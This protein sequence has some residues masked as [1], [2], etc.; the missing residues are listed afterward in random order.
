MQ[1]TKELLQHYI[2]KVPIG[3]YVGRNVDV[4]IGDKDD[5]YFDLVKGTIVISY[6]TIKDNARLIRTDADAEKSVRHLI[7]HELSHAL[8]TPRIL[9]IDMVLNVFEDERIESILKN[10]Y[11]DTD[12]KAFVKK[13]NGFKNQPPENEWDAW[14]QLVRYR[15]GPVYFLSRVHEIIDDYTHLDIAVSRI[16]TEIRSSIRNYETEVNHLYEEFVKWYNQTNPSDLKIDKSLKDLMQNGD[17][18]SQSSDRNNQQTQG[19]TC[20]SKADDNQSNNSENGLE[21]ALQK[22][23]ES[24]KD[25]KKDLLIEVP[26][27]DDKA[28]KFANVNSIEAIDVNEGDYDDLY[29][30]IDDSDDKAGGVWHRPG[31]D[32]D[33]AKQKA[34]KAVFDMIDSLISLLKTTRKNNGSSIAAYSGVINPRNVIRDDYKYFMQQNRKGHASVYSK[35]HLNMFIDCS[36]SFKDNDEKVN[37]LLWALTKFERAVPD[38]SYDLISCGVGQKLR[39]KYNRTQ[40]SYDGTVLTDDIFDM[41]KKQ[42]FTNAVN[43]N[44]VLYDGKVNH[45]HKYKTIGKCIESNWEAFNNVNTVIIVDDSNEEAVNKFCPLAHK[46]ISKDYVEELYK[47]TYAALLQLIRRT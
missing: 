17:G 43:M 30:I 34:D 42:Q 41:F 24:L 1:L 7:F 6:P 44:I 32:D 46:I 19:G 38:F 16:D 14:Y 29:T 15:R 9:H 23:L 25:N 33:K 8:L 18:D 36:A 45:L 31:K 39:P 11:L 20:L 2:N 37:T 35:M 40:S 12:F 3:Y 22:L 10:Y 27:V 21:K 4:S 47:N 28:N 26:K 5:T 13:L